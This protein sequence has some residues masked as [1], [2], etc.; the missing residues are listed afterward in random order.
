MALEPFVRNPDKF[1]ILFK[2]VKNFRTAD[3][4][5]EFVNLGNY[6]NNILRTELENIINVSLITVPDKF[7]IN[8]GDGNVV[9]KNIID[10]IANNSISLNKFQKIPKDSVLCSDALGNI[11]PI[12][13]EIDYGVLF[14][15][16]NN[17]HVWRKVVNDDIKNQ[18]LTGATIDKLE[19]I[20]IS[21]DLTNSFVTEDSLET[22][23]IVDSVID[24]SKII[25]GSLTESI[26]SIQSNSEV[27]IGYIPNQYINAR[28]V[29]NLL[30]FAQGFLPPEK[31]MDGSILPN[32]EPKI[33]SLMEYSDDPIYLHKNL[34]AGYEFPENF[35]L[36]VAEV[37]ES[38]NI[39]PNCLEDAHLIPY[40]NIGNFNNIPWYDDFE[41]AR[42]F[43]QGYII[44]T[45]DCKVEGRCLP[46]G[47]LRLRHFDDEVRAALI[48]KG[49]TDND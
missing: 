1:K 20:N 15:M 11:I 14:A 13:C 42:Y 12:T 44:P 10:V 4:Y 23:H 24:S 25:E 3:L 35:A 22:R 37:L 39:A 38:F 8:V 21:D 40:Q 5:N 41:E 45:D 19:Q 30:A 9:W 7:L 34:D 18:S 26:L 33:F 2:T 28:G 36:N 17:T 48:A 31:I 29:D 27:N 32:T 49:V 16:D 6:F 46:L 43:Q 47:Q